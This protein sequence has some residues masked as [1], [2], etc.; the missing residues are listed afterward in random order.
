MKRTLSLLLTLAVVGCGTAP[1]TTPAPSASPTPAATASPIPSSQAPSASATAS[2]AASPTPAPSAGSGAGVA[3]TTDTACAEATDACMRDLIEA[4][5]T[6]TEAIPT[7]VEIDSPASFRG[8]QRLDNWVVYLADTIVLVDRFWARAFAAGN[9][10]YTHMWYVLVDAGNRPQTS[11]CTDSQGNPG[12]ASAD[13][14]PF[15]CGVGGQAFGRT[16][17]NGT[18]YIG[19]PWLV[20][21]ASK[22]NPRNYDFAVVAVVAHEFGHHL[23]Q[24][25]LRQSA[26]T[27]TSMTWSEL[28][29][30]CL[31][32]VMANNAYYGRAGQLTDTDVQEATA[33]LYNLGN[34]LP[35]DYN[36]DPH[37]TREQRVA[38]FTQGYNTGNTSQCLRTTW[39]TGF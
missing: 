12:V 5:A 13:A 38:A 21:E 3:G 24:V 31:A 34:D 4:A 16:F 22:V 1:Q 39:P 6:Q 7:R 8:G 15:Y 14:G 9:V 11:A 18:V 20:A 28:S 26:T 30:D 35:Y 37:G 33:L 27:P 2:A 23:Q 25:L 29:A 19:V 10:P 17:T 36:L 32:G